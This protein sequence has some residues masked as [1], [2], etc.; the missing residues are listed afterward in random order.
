MKSIRSALFSCILLLLAS[1]NLRAGYGEMPLRANLS[2]KPFCS[3]EGGREDHR[4]S[5]AEINRYRIYDFYERQARWHLDHPEDTSDLL[6]PFTEL[7]GGRRG[8]WGVT[9]EPSTTAYKRTQQ[10]EFDLLTD[11]GVKEGVR[12]LMSGSV[13]ARALIVLTQDGSLKEVLLNGSMTGS[14][15]G[16]LRHKV[17]I[18]GLSEPRRH[19]QAFLQGTGQDLTLGVDK[20]RVCGFHYHGNNVIFRTTLGSSEILDL[21]QVESESGVPFLARHLEL[22]KAVQGLVLTLP[23]AANNHEPSIVEG[24]GTRWLVT[25]GKVRHLAVL[26]GEGKIAFDPSTQTFRVDSGN[27]GV[28]VHL[29][30]WIAETQP[31]ADWLAK[32]EER[33]QIHPSKML[34]GGPERFPGTLN[35]KCQLNADPAAAKSSYEIDDIG[36]PLDNPW[37]LP[38]CLSG[39]AFTKNGNAFV[40]TLTGEI[41]LV[42]GIDDGLSTVTWKRYAMGLNQPMGIQIVDD[43][44]VVC[45]KSG[46]VRLLDHTGHEQADEVVFI[47]QVPMPGSNPWTALN[48]LERDAS[49][50]YYFSTVDGIFRMSADGSRIDR[51]GGGSR[52]PLNISVRPDGLAISDASE[53]DN[54][55]GCCSLHEAQHDENRKTTS[56]NRRLLYLP[57]G[58]DNSC[59]DRIFVD[60]SRFGPLGKSFFGTSYGAG[61]SYVILRDPNEGV[62]QAALLPLP[63]EFASGVLQL[64]S[65]PN[66][67]QLY[68]CGIDGWGDY[69]IS[70]GSLHRIRWNGKSALLPTSWQAH[71][72]GILLRFNQPVKA[73]AAASVFSQQWNNVDYRHSYGSPDY[74]IRQPEDIGHDRLHVNRVHVL[75]D[76][77]ELFLEIPDLLPSMVTQ[78]FAAIEGLNGSKLKLDLYATINRLRTNHPAGNAAYEKPMILSVPV[79]EKNP[80]G[81]T[82]QCITEFFDRTSGRDVASRP[83]APAKEWKKEQLN[84]QWISQNILESQCLMCHGKGS[85]HDYTTYEGLVSKI[86]LE[87]PE[88]S[89]LYG[90]VA[91][92]SMP[93]YPLPTVAPETM[94]ALLEWIK[95]G[96]PK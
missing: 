41:W 11:R 25:A 18:Y 4:F 42:K 15:N 58:V 95:A 71:S 21:A 47:N 76:G 82:Y 6:L 35:V 57:R 39:I 1:G 91:T 86:N 81:D 34:A 7:D 83:V 30:S 44:P 36:V 88:K 5:G 45:T 27:S 64:C 63:G 56:K 3:T 22:Q 51:I 2:D 19:G 10:P 92:R 46:I 89:H 73:P 75:E 20:P 69:A 66:D 49:G 70:E 24:S 38:M 53:G 8:H 90:M 48:G 14:P 12:V 85:P 84:Y 74:S 80:A 13:E 59:G 52:N 32:L 40:S 61:R 50:N 79:K 33:S 78:I 16:L 26:N 65:N 94:K 67:G 23:R 28:R 55:N 60:D 43:Q 62:P 77:R 17:D 37:N 72:N 54:E 96:A 68:T 31:Q 9:N 87:N 29:F 93:P